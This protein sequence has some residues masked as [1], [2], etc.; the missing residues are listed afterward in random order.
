MHLVVLTT[1]AFQ[2]ILTSIALACLTFDIFVLL[3]IVLFFVEYFFWIAQAI[4][5]AGLMLRTLG[6][7]KYSNSNCVWFKDN[8]DNIKEEG[9]IVYRRKYG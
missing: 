6:T 9:R 7:R 2:L 8:I 3:R 4:E 5:H 1:E